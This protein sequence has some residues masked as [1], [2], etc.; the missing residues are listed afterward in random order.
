ME[1]IDRLLLFSNLDYAAVSLLF[2]GWL[3]IGWII[4]NPPK[5][6][7]STSRLMVFYREEWM[8]Q[9]I[10]RDPR[11]YDAQILTNLRQGTAFF[12]SASMIA[13]GGGLALIGNAERLT[14]VASELTL[15]SAPPIVWEIKLIVMLFFVANAF[16]KFVWSHRVFG[17]VAIVMSAVPVDPKDP[18]CDLRTRQASALHITGAKSYNR[19]LRGVYFGLTA[20]AWLAGATALILACLLTLFI[21]WRR[22]FASHSRAALLQTT[23]DGVQVK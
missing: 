22:E 10:V 5:N 18:L 17:Y 13:V 15:V 2:V 3:V 9:F 12:I 23:L 7:Q 11:I 19:G 6:R 4:E 1:W 21:I 20:T 14:G 8:R 16:L